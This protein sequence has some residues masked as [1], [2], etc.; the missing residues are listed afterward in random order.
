MVMLKGYVHMVD[1]FS[2]IPWWTL[3][4]RSELVN[5]GALCLADPGKEYVIYLPE[6]GSA[7]AKLEPGHYRAQRFNPRTGKYSRLPD[8]DAAEWKSP[9][10]E[11]G[12][13]WI[14]HLWKK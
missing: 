4:P 5:E 13:D 6:G 8:A 7:A 10:A 2:R 11:T 3:E 1:F 9:E 14:L 12:A